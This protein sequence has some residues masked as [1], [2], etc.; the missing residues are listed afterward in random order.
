MKVCSAEVTCSECFASLR[1]PDRALGK[2]GRCRNCGAH[3]QITSEA[4]AALPPR[5][6]KKKT[7]SRRTS[8]TNAGSD[9]RPESRTAVPLVAGGV[10]LAVLAIAGLFVAFSST[11]KG[12]TSDSQT[13]VRV[14]DRTQIK[15]TSDSDLAQ[16]RTTSEWLALIVERRE[17]KNPMR[18]TMLKIRMPNPES[19]LGPDPAALPKVLAALENPILGRYAEAIVMKFSTTTEPPYL[20]DVL[21]GL[22]SE[23]PRIVQASTRLLA[24]VRVEGP[25]T[26]GTVAKFLQAPT[27]EVYGSACTALGH[28]GAAGFEV[29]HQELK[30]RLDQ[31]HPMLVSAI[32][33]HAAGAADAVNELAELL[34][35]PNTALRIPVL[36]ALQ[37]I[38]EP[39]APALPVLTLIWLAESDTKWRNNIRDTLT[40]MGRSSAS[41]MAAGFR[42]APLPAKHVAVEV[43]GS[44][45]ATESVPM[46]VECLP[47]FGG[48]LKESCCVALST[49]LPQSEI[50]EDQLCVV[51]EFGTP[52]VQQWALEQLAVIDDAVPRN[53]ALLRRMQQVFRTTAIQQKAEAR[54]ID[55]P[56]TVTSTFRNG[57][58]VS[59]TRSGQG[60]AAERAAQCRQRAEV[61]S[62]MVARI[63]SLLTN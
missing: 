11:P 5:R 9:H 14:V 20:E 16:S 30:A 23:H 13:P 28:M 10:A 36:A 29:L 6:R 49:L 18:R 24:F 46:L 48:S 15:F 38:G 40:A 45:G 58:L 3:V 47:E 1:F 34:R 44:L 4:P 35:Q 21:A 62:A 19:F 53:S 56:D 52:P 32:G 60:K 41:A 61:L 54:R 43:F 51:L 33:Q 2:R 17:T 39:A 22:E 8:A 25:A 31:P 63:D 42:D 55:P 57:E 26:V 12:E 50:A 27:T 37:R 7:K 59:R